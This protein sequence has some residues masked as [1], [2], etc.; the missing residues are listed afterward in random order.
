MCQYV[1]DV[2]TDL[3]HLSVLPVSFPET[4]I[5]RLSTVFKWKNRYLNHR[6][7]SVHII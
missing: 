2:G 7:L 1:K 4:L 6:D 5:V 3:S